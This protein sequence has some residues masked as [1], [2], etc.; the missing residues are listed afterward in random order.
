MLGLK[1]VDG[2]VMV[3]VSLISKSNIPMIAGEILFTTM[4]LPNFEAFGT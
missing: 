1:K 3:L 4:I 2:T